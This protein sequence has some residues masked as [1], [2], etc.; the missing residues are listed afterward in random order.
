MAVRAMVVEDD[1]L[2]RELLEVLLASRGHEVVACDNAL[3]ALEE[4]QRRP[5]SLVLLDWMMEGMDGLDLCRRLRSMPDGDLPVILVVTARDQPEDLE[6]V[7][8]AGADDYITKPIDPDLMGVRLAVAEQSVVQR[9]QRR[10]ALEDLE[11]ALARLERSNRDLLSILDGLGVGTMLLDSDG[12]VTFLSQVGRRM[13]RAGRKPSVGLH[14]SALF[15][16]GGDAV[17]K[18]EA[19]MQAS[20]ARRTPIP[21]TLERRN[22]P[23]RALEVEVHDDPRD[24]ARRILAVYD[25]TEVQVLRERL[26]AQRR[27]GRLVGKSDR[28]QRV[29]RLIK[30]VARVDA[31]VLI[32]GE[33]GTGKELVARSIHESSHRRDRPF[34]AV[35][36]AGLTDSLLTSQLFGHRRGAFTGAVE[37]RQGFFE[38]ANGGTIFLDEIGDIPM[39]VQTALLRVI[40]EREIIRLGD[41]RPRKIDVRIIAATHRDLGEEVAHQRFRADLLYRIRVARVPLPPLRARREDIPLLANTFLEELRAETGKRVEVVSEEAMRRLVTYAW[42]GNVRELRS[43]IE[44]ALIQCRGTAILPED[45]PP[46]LSSARPETAPQPGAVAAEAEMDEPA[47]MREALRRTSGNRAAAARL[48]GMSRATFYRR[49]SHYG[50]VVLGASSSSRTGPTRASRRPGPGAGDP[51]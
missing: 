23:S 28:M 17:S 36:C 39:N 41:A 25:V 32:E 40:Q 2:M 19:A 12:R 21:V 6:A 38:A 26:A 13:L 11:R 27:F 16:A 34:V 37:D 47:R 46:E 48:L 8:D 9:A 5:P 18:I 29:F 50:E 44:F 51:D 31:T 42:P 24:P 45:L 15:R 35:N 4:Y 49:L 1:P 22:Q 7:L 20:P 43:A 30:D 3:E 10:A 14:W 33:T